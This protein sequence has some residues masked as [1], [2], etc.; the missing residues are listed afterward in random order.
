MKNDRVLNFLAN[1]LTPA[2]VIGITGCSPLYL[3]SLIEDEEFK[4]ELA[5]LRSTGMAESVDESANVS[6][7]YLSLEHR[8]LNAIDSSLVQ[9]ELKD[10]VRAL[11]VTSAR[12][13]RRADRLAKALS[14]KEIKI[15]PTVVL[16]IPTHAIPEYVV[17]SHRDIIAIGDV[18]M[19]PMTSESVQ[20]LFAN[21]NNS[22]IIE[23]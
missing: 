7:K 16:V 13:D 3:K 20:N 2:Q 17:N 12:Q 23:A 21:T 9:A 14:D 1:G 4:G 10:L 15:A 19:I 18:Q 8:I 11:E 22:A 5:K 6:D